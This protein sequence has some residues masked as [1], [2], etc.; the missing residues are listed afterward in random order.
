VTSWHLSSFS[1]LGLYGVLRDWKTERLDAHLKDIQYRQFSNCKMMLKEVNK[2]FG[3]GQ[4]HFRIPSAGMFFFLEFRFAPEAMMML[5]GEAQ[6]KQLTNGM[7]FV[8]K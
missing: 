2:V 5:E 1:Q 7:N 6:E 3:G 4:A 8:R